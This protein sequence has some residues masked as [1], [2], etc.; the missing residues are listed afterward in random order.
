MRLCLRSTPFS[1]S[2]QGM[3]FSL[4]MFVYLDGI[5]CMFDTDV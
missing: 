5:E 3:C 1:F 2:G 4:K